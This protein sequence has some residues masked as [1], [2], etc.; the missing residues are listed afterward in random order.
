MT[1]I[2]NKYRRQNFKNSTSYAIPIELS[3]LRGKIKKLDQKNYLLND[4][5]DA[6]ELNGGTLTFIFFFN[7]Q[8]EIIQEIGALGKSIKTYKSFIKDQII[9]WEWFDDGGNLTQCWFYEYPNNSEFATFF[10]AKRF[11]EAEQHIILNIENL[12]ANSF[13]YH[14]KDFDE[15]YVN[16][17]LIESKTK[18]NYLIFRYEYFE[19]S[20]TQSIYTNQIL[21]SVE[22]FNENDFL[23]EKIEFDKKGAITFK[24][25]VTYDENDNL[26]KTYTSRSEDGFEEPEI[27]IYNDN[28]L[29]IEKKRLSKD[30]ELYTAR[31]YEYDLHGN[32]V[33]EKGDWN[34]AKF[35]YTYDEFNN[36]TE[37]LEIKAS[38]I[39]CRTTREIEYY[40]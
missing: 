38:K 39:Y 14:G 12:D 29:L 33:K 10:N 2:F 20:Y 9:R 34:N 37:R 1:N 15:Y 16:N 21:T 17:E 31:Q 23:L 36:W 7:E 30:S 40:N 25:N 26:T 5:K 28:N 27:F 8:G 6:L 24:H 3:N 13:I 18:D 11:D 4:K 19:D 35:Q 22:K 32:L